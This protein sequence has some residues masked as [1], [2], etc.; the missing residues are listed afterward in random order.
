MKKYL[1]HGSDYSGITELEARSKLYNT[2][3]KVV[4]LTDNIP[5]ALYYIWDEKHNG[6]SGKHVTGWIKNGV[7]YYEEQFPDQL[8]TFYKG[9]SGYLYCISKNSG[10]Q[11]VENRECLYYSLKNTVIA[12]V[13]YISDVYEELL[14][15]EA[16]GK[17]KVLRYNEQSK[18]R[19]DELIDLIA[20]SI[21]KSDF[22]KD[23]EAKAQFMKK[24]FVKAW[25]KALK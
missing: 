24:Y 21:V 11:S 2:D 20:I 4:Y 10:I 16:S 25:E 23:N 19:Q 1:Y 22:F 17:F 5:Y 15:Y 8:K 13:D 9:V 14:K 6:Y 12:K 3:K 7:A 18:K